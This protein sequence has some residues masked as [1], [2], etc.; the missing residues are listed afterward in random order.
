MQ[1]LLTPSEIRQ[2]KITPSRFFYLRRNLIIE[3]IA[4]LYI[5]LF[6]YTAINKFI[7]IDALKITLKEYP[8]IGHYPVVVAWTLPISEMLVAILL[9]IPRFKR[10]GLYSSL[11]LMVTFTLYLGYMLAFTPSLPC[12]CGG[13]LQEL[14]WPQHLILNI[15]L[16]ILAISA[17]WL[18]KSYEEQKVEKS[19]INS[20]IFHDENVH[21]T[22]PF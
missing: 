11:V 5:T 13:L 7:E 1:N 20:T 9:F 2:K 12:T 4:G 3:I 18:S 8:L 14:T 16:I 21:K 22:N 10:F 19:Q 6:A 15:C 17:I